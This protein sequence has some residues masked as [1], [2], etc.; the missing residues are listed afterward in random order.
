MEKAMVAQKSYYDKKHQGYTD[1][2]WTA[3]QWGC[4]PQVGNAQH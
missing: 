3:T 4:V 1:A 2:E